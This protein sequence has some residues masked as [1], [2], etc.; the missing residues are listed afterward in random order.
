MATLENMVGYFLSYSTAIP[1]I[2]EAVIDHDYALLAVRKCGE[3]TRDIWGSTVNASRKLDVNVSEP[4]R[5]FINVDL[6]NFKVCVS[7]IFIYICVYLCLTCL[8]N[9][10]HSRPIAKTI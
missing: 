6:R 4:L 7:Y 8:G 9:E 2:S 1:H 3:T 5:N 10:A